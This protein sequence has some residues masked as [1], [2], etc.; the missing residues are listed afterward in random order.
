MRNIAR[1]VMVAVVFLYGT[2]MSFA[3][4]KPAGTTA[5]ATGTT[6]PAAGTT[7]P[8]AGTA[9]PATGAGA[10]APVAAGAGA[11]PAETKG[12]AGATTVTVAEMKG[13]VDVRPSA[14]KP[15]APATAGMK[16]SSDWE[17]ST[18]VNGQALL[19]FEDNSEVLVQRLTEMKIS[20]FSR[21][22]T[23]VKTRLQMKYGSVQIQV[24]KGTAANDFRVASPTGT[25]SVQGT[26]IEEFSYYRGLGNRLVMGDEGTALYHVNP[27]VTIGA[28]Q[29]TND[30]LV[31]PGTFAKLAGWT[32]TNLPGYT[33]EETK[34]S[35]WRETLG[36][37]VWQ[38][39]MSGT[40]GNANQVNQSLPLPPKHPKPPEPF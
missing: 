30:H 37:G 32:P 15:W 20:E 7:A 18:G 29:T 40:P 26:K 27:T 19:R 1:F 9:G 16:L 31:D 10:P 13:S 34:S 8:A 35:F 24:K 4:G 39:L 6:T 23:E 22:P 5:P 36:E 28:G 3:Q 25:A 38:N 2:Q 14:D 33:P 17:I 12:A 11:K 21:T